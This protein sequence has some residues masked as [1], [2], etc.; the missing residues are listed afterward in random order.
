M[1][2]VFRPQGYLWRPVKSVEWEASFTEAELAVIEANEAGVFNRLTIYTYLYIISMLRTY[3]FNNYETIYSIAEVDVQ[4]EQA[5]TSEASTAGQCVWDS[6]TENECLVIDREME[7][8]GA[9]NR[10]STHHIT[11]M[12]RLLLFFF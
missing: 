5:T 11:S 10:L 1:C 8:A 2:V 3:V 6:F 4:G 9:Y 7:K 12:V